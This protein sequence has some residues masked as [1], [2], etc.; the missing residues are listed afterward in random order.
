MTPLSKVDFALFWHFI[1]DM[2]SIVFEQSCIPASVP[3]PDS[4]FT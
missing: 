4:G 2:G 3:G 1:L